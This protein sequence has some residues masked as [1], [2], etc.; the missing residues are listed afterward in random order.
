MK[1]FLKSFYVLLIKQ[2]FDIIYSKI[3]LADNSFF[4]RNV[5]ENIVKLGADD[6]KSY[7]IYEIQN[8]RIYSDLSE[9]VAVIKK[10][11]LLPKVSIQLSKNYLIEEKYNQILNT[12]TR[13]FIQK[14]IK[15]NL[16][17]LVQG[18]SAINNY[19]H[20]M[21]DIIP[22]LLI[23]E[24][25]Q[26]LNNFDSIYLP[27]INKKFQK[28]TLKFFNINFSKIING[29]E[30]RHIFAEKIT[31]P[32]HP[33]WVTNKYQMETVAN[34]DPN[35]VKLV[36][37]KFLKKIETN[38]FKKIFIDRSDS[39]FFHN[40]IENYKEVWEI[41]DKKNF[42]RLKLTNLSFKEQM[43]YFNNAEVIVGGHGAGLCNSM[44]CKPGTMLIELAN[45][46]NKCNMFR[47]ISTINNMQHHKIESLKEPPKNRMKP[48]ILVDTSKLEFLLKDYT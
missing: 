33:Y 20:W 12:G 19:G 35:I 39:N 4:L 43:S 18:A 45:T 5:K 41:L 16:L 36:R 14:K 21:M 23:I 26:N 10:E 48:D 13:K 7:K 34:V 6:E 22:K 8:S 3:T 47:N 38:N 46:I 32:Q 25:K 11:F 37:K 17:S 29:S 42:T 1:K 2:I 24:T 15:G 9:N 31:I 44:F 40:Q 28:D 30:I 27:N